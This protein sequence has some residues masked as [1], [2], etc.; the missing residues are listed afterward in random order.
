VYVI[1]CRIYDTVI[2][3]LS[4]YLPVIPWTVRTKALF[5]YCVSWLMRQTTHLEGATVTVAGQHYAQL[6]LPPLPVCC[7][8]C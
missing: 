3:A 2:L 4:D 7:F 5:D 8:V 1:C 6:R